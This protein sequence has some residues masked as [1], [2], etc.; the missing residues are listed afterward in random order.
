MV[1]GLAAM[2]AV[3]DLP[4]LL[5]ELRRRQ[6]SDVLPEDLLRLPAQGG[7]ESFDCPGG[8]SHDVYF[9]PPPDPLEQMF[10]ERIG[11]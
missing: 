3:E 11:E 6:D 8:E 7:V 10:E 4:R 2:D 5:L 9:Y 1:D